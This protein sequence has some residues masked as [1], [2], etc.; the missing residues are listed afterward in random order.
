LGNCCGALPHSHETLVLLPALL[1]LLL[2]VLMLPFYPTPCV[3]FREVAA[4]VAAQLAQRGDDEEI[5]N[6]D[7][8]QINSGGVEQNN[9]E[10]NGHNSDGGDQEPSE[11]A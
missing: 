3:F 10:D 11:H 1:L 8:E 2:Q 6:A 7:V 9:D 4:Q 5:N